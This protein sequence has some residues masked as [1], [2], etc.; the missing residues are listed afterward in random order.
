MSGSEARKLREQT[1]L[2][3]AAWAALLAIN[4]Q[5]VRN[6]ESG[7]TEKTKPGKA[8]EQ[9]WRLNAVLH[10]KNDSPP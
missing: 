7:N 9:L 2:S 1:G 8:L 3:V 4:P 10:K 6:I 5:T